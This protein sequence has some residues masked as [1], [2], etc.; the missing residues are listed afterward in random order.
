M[1]IEVAKLGKTVG[2]KGF[3]KLHNLTDF[4]EQFKKNSSYE[5]KA[6]VLT[7]ESISAKKDEVKFFG[8][9]TKEDASKLVNLILLAEKEQSEKSCQLKE[10]EFFWYD[11]VGLDV[12]ESDIFIGTVKDIERYPLED[13]LQIQC[14]QEIVQR[15]KVKRFLLPYNKAKILKVD[16]DAKM[17]LVVGALEI[18]D[19]IG[20]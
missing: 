4:P 16:L 5:T 1:L 8:Y 12:Y 2:L 3:L 20:S 14:S 13:H 10:D 18:I 19:I 15:K 6:G 17:I 9:D 11:I 7:V